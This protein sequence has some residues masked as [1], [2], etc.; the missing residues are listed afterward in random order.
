MF[1]GGGERSGV[2]FISIDDSQGSHRR[3]G[4]GREEE[5]ERRFPRRK[6]KRVQEARLQEEG[7]TRRERAV[8]GEVSN[9]MKKLLLSC[10]LA[11]LKDET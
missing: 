10:D 7:W 2:L 8:F 6:R 9:Y 5:E 11:G 3:S 1:E 4:T